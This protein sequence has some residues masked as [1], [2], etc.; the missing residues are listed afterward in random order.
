MTLVMN[1]LITFSKTTPPPV[2][3]DRVTGSVTL[4][5]T[6]TRR[7]TPWSCIA[8][9]MFAIATRVERDRLAAVPGAERREDGILSGH[10]SV[11]GGEIERVSLDDAQLL[12]VDGECVGM[13]CERRDRVAGCERLLGQET[14]GG[15]VGAEDG[16]VHDVPPW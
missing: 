13:T 16:D 2:S 9:I 4:E 11:H 5:L 14:S 3:R 15:T 8:W 1:G 10:R 6:Q 7:W 12:V